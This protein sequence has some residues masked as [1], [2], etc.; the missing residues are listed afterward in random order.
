MKFQNKTMFCTYS[1]RT[2]I[3]GLPVHSSF[4]KSYFL[5]FDLE[6]LEKA[7]QAHISL[8]AEGST[9]CF[10]PPTPTQHVVDKHFKILFQPLKQHLIPR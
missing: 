5:S 2:Q 3:W 1:P 4:S 8:S 7:N 6:R 9:S 10:K